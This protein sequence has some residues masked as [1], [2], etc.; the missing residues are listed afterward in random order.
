VAV[1]VVATEF[2]SISVE[3]DSNLPAFDSNLPEFDSNLVA[4]DVVRAGE[5][6]REIFWWGRK[7]S[8]FLGL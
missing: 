2:D 1:D 8:V 5:E 6:K 3:F 7:K 4:F